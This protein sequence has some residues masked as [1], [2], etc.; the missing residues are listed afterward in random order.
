MSYIHQFLTEQVMYSTRGELI[1]MCE[2]VPLCTIADDDIQL[3]ELDGLKAD[4][5]SL[6]ASVHKLVS[7]ASVADLT[8]MLLSC[9]RINLLESELM[10][11]NEWVVPKK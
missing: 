8:I 6:Q 5:L 4:L 9:S 1:Y 7:V 11:L 10:V 2:Y 3:D